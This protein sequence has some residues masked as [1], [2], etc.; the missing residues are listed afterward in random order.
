MLMRQRVVIN[1]SMSSFFGWGVYGLNLALQWVND[2]D[3]EPMTSVPPRPSEICVNPLQRHALEP[4]FALS[5]TLRGV[6]PPLR[7]SRVV[8]ECPVLSELDLSANAFDLGIAGR[9]DIGLTFFDSARISDEALARARALPLI[10]AGSDWNRRVLNHYGLDNVATVPQGIDPALFHPAPAGGW[11]GDRFCVYSGGK[12]EHRKAQDIVLAAFR[13]F[14]RRHRE[15]LLVTTWHC[16]WPGLASSLDA[17]EMV[18]PVP[19]DANGG[20]DVIGWATANSIAKD[21]ILDLGPVANHDMP[22]ILREMD[23][24]VFPN[25]CE[26]GTNLVAMECM[27]CGLPVILS[28]NTGHLDLIDGDNCFPLEHQAPLDGHRAGVGAVPG[29]GESSVAEVVEQLERVFADRSTAQS[30][31]QRAAASMGRLN[32]RQ[33]A[34]RLKALVLDAGSWQSGRSE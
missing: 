19:L 25:R 3:I 29:W 2:P 28:R 8:V 31:G 23:V 27:A 13:E 20:V 16:P 17:S 14:A 33:T 5:E 18:S 10:V 9:P 21:Q 7:S 11:L 12:L 34:L 6:L 22:A 24:A 4:F 26:G 15:A 30:R 32:W 1:W